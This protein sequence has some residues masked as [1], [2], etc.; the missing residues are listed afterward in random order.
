MLADISDALIVDEIFIQLQLK[1]KSWK[2]ISELIWKRIQLLTLKGEKWI[3]RYLKIF[4]QK[5]INLF[6]SQ[7][8]IYALFNTVTKRCY[9]GQT[10]KSLK[11][12]LQAH[13]SSSKIDKLRPS[14][15]YIN[16]IGFENWIIYPLEIV[17]KNNIDKKEA[18]WL[19]NFRNLTVNDPIMWVRK[20]AKK[21]EPKNQNK[22]NLSRFEQLKEQRKEYRNKIFLIQRKKSNPKSEEWRNWSISTQIY[23]LI[24]LQKAKLHP[25]LV[26]EI[27]RRILPNL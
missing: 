5:K 18:T 26:Q 19:H 1:R 13:Y 27:K 25:K 11:N 10:Q 14:Y 9:V 21:L 3:K 17:E 8:Q 22:R 20:P 4:D 2:R 6:T 24:Q 7:P 23:L 15:K 12:R 16:K